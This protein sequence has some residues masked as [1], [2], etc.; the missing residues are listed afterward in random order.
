MIGLYVL[1]YKPIIKFMDERKKYYEDMDNSAKKALEDAKN[2][3]IQSEKELN[4]LK[5]E[6]D[7]IIQNAIKEAEEKEEA[8]LSQAKKDAEKIVKDAVVSAELEREKIIQDANNDV[9]NMLNNALNNLMIMDEPFKGLDE[10][11]KKLVMGQVGK[12]LVEKTAIIVTHDKTE[13]DFFRSIEGLAIREI[14]MKK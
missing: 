2:A 11:N 14:D 1:L 9:K 7:N 8:Y 3:Q 4:D 10:E 12:S 6:S 5:K 13:I